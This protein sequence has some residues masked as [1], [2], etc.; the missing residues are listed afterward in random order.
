M[1]RNWRFWILAL[2]QLGPPGV[3]IWMGFLWLN[4]RDWG[5]YGFLGWLVCG[6]AFGFLVVRWTRSR[7]PV[8]PPIDWDAPRTFA[9]RDRQAW[10]VVQAEAEQADTVPMETLISGDIYVDTGRRLAEKIAAHYH[11]DSGQPV[12]RVAV[13]D[14]LT[15]LELA[16]EDLGRLCR[17]VPG[18]DM[19]TPSHWKTA[20]QAANYISKANEIY[21]YILPFFQP[22]VGLVRLGTQ[23]LMMQPAWKNMQQNL[24]RWFFRAYV[25]RLGTHLI[26]LYSGR[27]AIGADQYRRLTGRSPARGL[28]EGE[29][30]PANLVIAV[31][32]ARDSGKSA[33][34]AALESARQR[35]LPAVK[36]RLE[37]AG[38]DESL[39]EHLKSA[40]LVEVDSYT[41]HDTEVARDR[42]T[43]R[44]AVAEAVECDLLLLV[45]DG[46]RA[47]AG[48][49][50]KFIEAW[51]DWYA[52]QHHREVPPALAVVTGADRPELAG[53][54][55]PQG[56][57]VRAVVTRSARE[58]ALKARVESIRRALPPAIVDVIPVGLGAAPPIGVEDRL[59]PE[60][61]ALM[62]RAEKVGLIRYLHHHAARS[63][64]RR[65][66]GQVGRQ[67]RRLFGALRPSR[68]KSNAGG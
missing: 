66:L 55:E 28:G 9:P 38:F 47:D 24:L 4:E 63:K 25:N 26:E 20:A 45:V 30:G 67:G 31:A 15:A 22:A 19:V 58:A 11:P 59:L 34:I 68:K 37:Q 32:G 60:V 13:V 53:E 5:L 10:E 43:R 12:T 27:L 61:A 49:E 56:T 6:I 44:D 41:V 17:E 57:G 62:H 21:N 29:S 16:A 2:L 14:I 7:N 54:P 52:K 18:G 39:A 40:D 8:L 50:A 51:L 3:L 46:R 33:L 1:L 23:K 42:Y 64:A 36:E 35:A 48:P 65:F